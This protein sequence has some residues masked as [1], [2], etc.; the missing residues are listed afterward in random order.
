M[1]P[2]LVPV[3]GGT[4]LGSEAGVWVATLTDTFS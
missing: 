3:T 1:G 2:P 4:G